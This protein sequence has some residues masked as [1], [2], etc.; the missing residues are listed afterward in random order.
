MSSFLCRLKKDL[1]FCKKK[2]I[3]EMKDFSGVRASFLTGLSNTHV[4]RTPEKNNGILGSPSLYFSI[5][6]MP[7]SY[8][9]T[10]QS[11]LLQIITL[12]DFLNF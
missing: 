4:R 8:F 5:R 10:G 2:P 6:S 7:I 9:F 12:T 3:K 1:N 11:A